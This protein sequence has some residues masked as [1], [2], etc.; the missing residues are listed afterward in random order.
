M[1]S[2]P[3]FFVN[4]HFYGREPG[5]KGR[6]DTTNCLDN[7]VNTIEKY[8]ISSL[9]THPDEVH[10]MCMRKSGKRGEYSP[11]ILFPGT[12]YVKN[13]KRNAD[14]YF[15]LEK[16]EKGQYEYMLIEGYTAGLLFTGFRRKLDFRDSRDTADVTI[17]IKGN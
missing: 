14:G 4:Q 2:L 3:P 15:M 13:V 16:I 7:C 10:F 1:G 12:V 6:R 9:I 17:C 11:D 8:L 5:R